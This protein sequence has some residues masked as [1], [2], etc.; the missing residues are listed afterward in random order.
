MPDLNTAW[1]GRRPV[2]G[3]GRQRQ[4]GRSVHGLCARGATPARRR[5]SAKTSRWPRYRDR[6][7]QVTRRAPGRRQRDRGRTGGARA[8]APGR[9]GWPKRPAWRC[10]CRP[11]EHMYVVTEPMAGLAAAVPGGARSGPRHLHQGRCGQTGDRRVRAGCQV[12]GRL[13]PRRRPPVSGT[14]RGLGPVHP[15]H[16]GGA[17]LIPALETAGIAHFMNGPESFTADTRPLI[18]ETP[19]VAGCSWRRA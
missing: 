17:A 15:L 12:L 5:R 11:V 6:R 16:G 14:A 4:S 7:R 9:N 19:E 13:R 10:R 8:P 2:G 3:R 18:G 1:S